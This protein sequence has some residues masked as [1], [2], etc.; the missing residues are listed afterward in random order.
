SQNDMATIRLSPMVETSRAHERLA[1]RPLGGVA[2]SLAA[3]RA[4]WAALWLPDP[5]L[6]R[7]ALDLIVHFHGAA[8]LPQQAV[9]SL[10]GAA[11][12][13]V[14]LGA[15]SGVY[16]RAFADPAEFDALLAGVARRSGAGHIAPPA[17][18]VESTRDLRFEDAADGSVVVRAVSA[19]GATDDVAVLRSGELMFVRSTLRALTRGRRLDGRADPRTPFRVTR[20]RDGRMTL[21]DLA[22]R[23]H[24]E[25]GAYG[26]DNAAAFA[27]LLDASR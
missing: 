7:D 12:V 6:G 1:P 5:A 24:L 20:Y 13:V 9:A 18:V 3:P 23:Q 2:D 27:K 8:W 4:R 22:T 17:G 19:A 10:G 16:H 21:D 14:N 11:A 15:G 26:P 25:L